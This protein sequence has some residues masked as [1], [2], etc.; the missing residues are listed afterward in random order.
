MFLLQYRAPSFKSKRSITKEKY[1]PKLKN[2]EPRLGSTTKDEERKEKE[3]K[4]IRSH[5]NEI[6]TNAP[7]HI[8]GKATNFLLYLLLTIVSNLVGIA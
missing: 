2:P 6:K 8:F 1:S 5:E 4:M 7:N 3:N